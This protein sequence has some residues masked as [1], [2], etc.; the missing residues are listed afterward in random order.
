MSLWDEKRA[1][2][3]FRLYQDPRSKKGTQSILCKDAT[4]FII[5]PGVADIACGMGHLVPYL[6]E[7]FRD[8]RY[9]G[10]DSSPAMLKRA[11]AFFPDETFAEMNATN[12]DSGLF[13][14]KINTAVALS[15]FI[16]LSKEDMI[17][18]LQGM[19]LLAK[20]AVVFGM[21]T[22]DDSEIIRNDGMRIR[23]QSVQNIIDTL[24]E[25]G[26]D[27]K[28]I[29]HYHQSYTYQD[30]HTLIPSLETPLSSSRDLIARTTLFQVML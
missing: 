17:K 4:E 24:G 7:K 2:R 15:L 25:L 23:N 30:T 22:V 3:Y 29:L 1:E 28:K 21:E 10:V 27:Q 6:V 19:K 20:N 5:G 16:H 13:R 11:R 26:F 9:V 12:V 8:L 14:D 18:V